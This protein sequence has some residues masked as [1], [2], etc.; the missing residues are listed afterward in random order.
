M[1]SAF[2]FKQFQVRDQ[3]STMRVGTDAVLLGAWARPPENGSILDI[4]TG[5][6]VLALMMAQ[7]SKAEIIAIDIHQES[8]QQA[9]EN[10]RM[11]PWHNRLIARHTGISEFSV[12]YQSKFNY[13]ISNPPF[14][15][16]SLKPFSEGRILARHM[17]PGFAED[18]VRS[19]HRLLEPDG[20]AALIVPPENYESIVPRFETHG[21]FPVRK[22]FVFSKPGSAMRRVMFEAAFNFTSLPVEEEIL[23][24]DENLAYSETYKNLTAGFYL[25]NNGG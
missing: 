19:I 7:K 23:I 2:R 20:K 9:Q 8:I 18:F 10:F 17:Q 1:A 12:S 15:N 22:A 16:N 5:C 4:G 13:I 11:S 21:I 14:F 24:M 25:F 6:G 3:Q